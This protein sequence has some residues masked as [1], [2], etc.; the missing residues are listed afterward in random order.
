[1]H[2]LA[3]AFADR[4][5]HIICWTSHVAAQCVMYRSSTSYTMRCPP[6]RGYD[7]RALASGLAYVQSDKHGITIL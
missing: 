4:T 5:Y 1:M 2:R 7:P 6:V 3:R